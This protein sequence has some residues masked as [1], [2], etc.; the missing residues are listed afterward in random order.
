MRTHRATARSSPTGAPTKPTPDD[1]DNA[2]I[3]ALTS[4]IVQLKNNTAS[5][6][7]PYKQP[8]SKPTARTSNFITNSLAATGPGP[9]PPP[10]EA[11]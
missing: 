2:I 8:S 1:S 3:T 5:K 9:L 4:Q 7:K 6:S 11:A 10:E